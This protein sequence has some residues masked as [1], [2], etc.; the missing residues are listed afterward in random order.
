MVLVPQAQPAQPSDWGKEFLDATLAVKV[1][2]D[3]QQA[4]EHIRAYGSDH[5]E[6][7]Y[8]ADLQVA[9]QFLTSVDSSS[10]M[11]NVPTIFADGGEYGLG[12]EIG[13]STNRL[14]ARGPV[15]AQDLTSYKYLVRGE[16]QVRV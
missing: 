6:A 4:I 3:C 12:A 7:I 5:T 9:N 13:I 11:H 14:H 1:V 10:V 8:A 2:D 16:G 15:G